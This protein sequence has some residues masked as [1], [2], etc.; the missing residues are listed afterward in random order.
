[1][2]FRQ[3]LL[4][5][6]IASGVLTLSLLL[7]LFKD[8]KSAFVFIFI[9]A[10]KKNGKRDTNEKLM[11]QIVVSLINKETGNIALDDSGKKITS[12]TNV[13]GEYIFNNII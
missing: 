1:M 6:K 10:E 5:S 11:E 2:V 9:V 8:P 7:G 4:K 3:I 13:N 12:V